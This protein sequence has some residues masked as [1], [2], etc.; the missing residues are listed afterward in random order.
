LITPENEFE[1]EIIKVSREVAELVI[2]RNRSYGDSYRGVRK[3]SKLLF[4]NVKIPFWIHI[5]EKLKRFLSPTDNEDPVIDIAGYGILE[6][7][8]RRLDDVN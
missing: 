4:N 1:T 8:C 3:A 7:V 6:I 5:W 2:N